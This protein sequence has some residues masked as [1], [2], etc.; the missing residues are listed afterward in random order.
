MK[1]LQHTSKTFEM[2]ACNMHRIAV[3]PPPPF[4][5]RR[6]SRSR[7]RGQ[8]ASTLGPDASPYVAASVAS[9]GA[10]AVRRSG[11][12]SRSSSI[13]Q[14]GNAVEQEKKQ[15]GVTADGGAGRRAGAAG[16]PT[17]QEQTGWAL[18]RGAKRSKSIVFF[19]FP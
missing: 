18:T 14:W 17:E 5:L 12:Q 10:H 1:H 8:R 13:K 7:R 4:A 16:R 19:S 11:P 2:Y 6:R 9:G 15:R 3:R